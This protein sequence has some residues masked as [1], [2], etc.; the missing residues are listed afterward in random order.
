[1][2]WDG[3]FINEPH[4]TVSEKL[5]VFFKYHGFVKMRL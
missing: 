4:K 5:A 1:M 3:I 2:G